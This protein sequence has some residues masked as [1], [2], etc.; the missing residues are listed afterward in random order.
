MTDQKQ[1]KILLV[2]NSEDRA[3]MLTS[4]LDICGYRSVAQIPTHGKIWEEIERLN[5]DV[6]LI[7]VESPTRDT[8]EQLN[9][10]RDRNPKP[11]VLFTQDTDV[12][13]IRAAINSGVSAYVVDGIQAERVRPAIEIA[14]ATFHSFQTLRDELDQTKATLEDQTAI[15]RA[16]ALL[17]NTKGYTEDQA[18][19]HLRKLAMNQK[20]KLA[21]V[22]RRLLELEDLLG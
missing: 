17:S 5:P 20:R 11:V 21:D 15:D 19:H 6:I 13:S 3:R 22:S 2:D 1:V 4:A 10:I 12:Q 9:W 18:Y 14:M 7:D 8:L 16:K